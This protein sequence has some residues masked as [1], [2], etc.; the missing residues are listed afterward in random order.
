MIKYTTKSIDYKILSQTYKVLTT[1]QPSDL[2]NLRSVQPH[3]STRSSD[4]LILSRPPTSSSLKVNNR[5]FR[6]ASPCLWNQLPKDRNFACLHITK[7]YHSYLISHTSVR[8]FLHHHC[9]HPLLLLSSTPGSKLIFSTNP[10]LHYSSS[11]F[12]PT[13][14]TPWTPAV[15]RFS[16][17]CRF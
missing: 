13:G 6:H 17:E 9:H 8:H 4:V 7:T 10:F 2:C 1:T 16:Q 14:L 3:R 15:F 5:S 11:I 12:P